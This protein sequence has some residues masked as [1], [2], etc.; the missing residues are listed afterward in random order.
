MILPTFRCTIVPVL[1]ASAA[2]TGHSQASDSAATGQEA[3]CYILLKSEIK[4]EYL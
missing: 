3:C 4:K 2:T 1:P